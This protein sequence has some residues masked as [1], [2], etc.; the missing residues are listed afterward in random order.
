[1][2]ALKT[3]WRKKPIGLL[4]GLLIGLCIFG[5]FIFEPTGAPRY[6][7]VMIVSYR[8]GARGSQYFTVVSQATGQSWEVGA[9]RG[10]FPPDYRGP[11]VVVARRGRW[12]GKD[13]FQLLQSETLTNRLNTV[14]EPTGVGAGS[15]ASRSTSQPAD[16]SAFER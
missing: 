4:V 3:G 10:P 7:D 1:M 9:A 14:L 6:L 13:H 2:G 8:T 11:A 16:G 15:S 12:T 5:P